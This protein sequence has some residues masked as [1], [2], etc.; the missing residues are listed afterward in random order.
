MDFWQS[1][2]IYAA[3]AMVQHGNRLYKSLQDA[4]LGNLPDAISSTWWVLYVDP[5]TQVYYA[6][7]ELL[8]AHVPLAAMVRVG[9]RIKFSGA[10]R[11]PM[12]DEVSGAD[13]PEI[14]VLPVSSEPHLQRTSNGSSIVKR[15]RVVAAT[16]DQRVDA[17]LF[18]L[19]WEIYRA[20]SSWATVLM[21]LRWK[22][23]PYVR[24]AKPISVE[25]GI[26]R[27]DMERGIKGWASIWEVEVSMWFSTTD[28]QEP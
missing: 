11:D 8:E 6:L 24:L 2:K 21:S 19:E 4:N 13:F 26:S 25:D 3:G 5:I 15:F 18:P 7:W 27:T 28:L 1:D 16:G 10:N 9:N 22:D 12:K 17:G 14:R 23:K 20:L